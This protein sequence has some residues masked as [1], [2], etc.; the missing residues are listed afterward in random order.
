MKQKTQIRQSAAVSALLLAALFLIPLAVVAP[1][2]SELF[3][4]EDTVDETEPF[5]PGNLDGQAVLRVLSGDT[6]EEMD[7]GTYLVGVVR[8]E[9]PASFE[10]EALKAQAVAARTYTIYKIQTGGNHGDTADICTDSTC[11][12]AY[13]GEEQARA[14]WGVNADAYEKKIEEAV[15]ST[16]GQAIL[17]GGAPVLA[18]FHSSSAGLTRAAGEVWVNDLPYL[19][20]V[21]SPEAG[22]TIPN[23]YSRV[24]FTPA[25]FRERFLASCPA[26]DLSGDMSGWLRDAVTDSAGSVETVTVGG[27]TVKG[28][29][30]RSVLGLRSA[31][32]TWEVEDGKLV[33]FVTGYGH[34]VGMSQYGANAMAAGGADYQEILT[35]YYT[36]VTV[37]PYTFTT[38]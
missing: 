14:N 6:V 19:Q 30:V 27:V 18:V 2:R 34:G 3:D 22:D 23:Y 38:P 7:L 9:M 28:T 12:Q 37:E 24:E 29:Q 17:Y 13:I 25:E 32:F 8:A 20:A 10:T 21:E 26:A 11:C 35:H 36:G 15:S 1:F 5:V 16:D 33:F 4:R 31:C